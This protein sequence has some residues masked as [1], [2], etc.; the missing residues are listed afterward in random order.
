MLSCWVVAVFLANPGGV[1]YLAESKVHYTE[2]VICL[3][4][5]IWLPAILNC[6]FAVLS[7][8]KNLH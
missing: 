8:M 6:L 1:G 7:F 2:V 3:T 4:V 5:T